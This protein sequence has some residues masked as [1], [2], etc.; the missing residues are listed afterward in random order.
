MYIP[1]TIFTVIYDVIVQIQIAACSDNGDAAHNLFDYI[2]KCLMKFRSQ[3]I[4]ESIFTAKGVIVCR[5]KLFAV[6]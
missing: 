2:I 3:H 5:F 4:P 6:K 1:K